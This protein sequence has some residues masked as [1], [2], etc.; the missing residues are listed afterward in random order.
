MKRLFLRRRL[1]LKAALLL[2]LL[3]LCFYCLALP[4][5]LPA[6]A[7]CAREIPGICPTRS[8]IPA[9][10]AADVRSYFGAPEAVSHH[11]A[12][13]GEATILSIAFVPVRQTDAWAPTELHGD[14]LVCVVQLH[15]LFAHYLM[16]AGRYEHGTYYQQATFIFDARTGD[17]MEAEVTP[18]NDRH[19]Q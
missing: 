3:P 4:A 1:L 5:A 2:V 13:I 12:F 18:F 10:T 14:A 16:F 6:W 8:G 15:G 11:T 19:T 7:S 9:F 17:M